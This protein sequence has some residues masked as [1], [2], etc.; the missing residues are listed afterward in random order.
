MSENPEKMDTNERSRNEQMSEKFEKM[1]THERSRNRKYRKKSEKMD[2]NERSRNEQVLQHSLKI[3]KTREAEM[4]KMSIEGTHARTDG[5]TDGGRNDFSTHPDSKP[6][7]VARGM[8]KCRKNSK[9]MDTN[10][11]SRNEQMSENSEKMD[12][13]ER[14]RNRKCRKIRKKCT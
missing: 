2:E 11:R 10:E 5:R 1:D 3:A 4:R 14:S 9:K 7:R 12:T 6:P 13:N 8:S